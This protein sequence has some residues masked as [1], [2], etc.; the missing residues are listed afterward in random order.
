MTLKS[1]LCQRGSGNLGCMQAQHATI[2]LHLLNAEICR[3]LWS[4]RVNGCPGNPDH[5]C[6]FPDVVSVA[7]QLRRSVEGL[8][9]DKWHYSVSHRVIAFQGLVIVLLCLQSKEM[10]YHIIPL[11]ALNDVIACCHIYQSRHACHNIIPKSKLIARRHCIDR[12][13]SCEE[14]QVLTSA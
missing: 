3:I 7:P 14:C 12:P 13:V 5:L 2:D 1:H 11:P 4:E 6:N 8:P 9:L 10:I